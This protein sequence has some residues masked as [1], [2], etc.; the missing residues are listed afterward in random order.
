MKK[1]GVQG[2]YKEIP[3]SVVSEMVLFCSVRH[4][5]F[6]ERTKGRKQKRKEK[7]LSFIFVCFL[8][9]ILWQNE[10]FMSENLTI[11]SDLSLR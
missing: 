7:F 9:S 3:K 5:E 2:L 6:S 1:S 11:N 8:Y 10:I 4:F